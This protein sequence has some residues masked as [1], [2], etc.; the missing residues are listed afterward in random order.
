MLAEQGE[1]TLGELVSASAPPET[2]FADE[3][4][5]EAIR[6]MGVLD[7]QLL[8]VVARGNSRHPIGLLG[9][10]DIFKAYSVA[11]LTEHA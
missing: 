4:L 9:L 10:D 3:H 7:Q 6:R 1:E 2:I 11:L 5:D 8:P